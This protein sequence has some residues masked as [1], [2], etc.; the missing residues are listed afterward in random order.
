[1]DMRNNKMMRNKTLLLLTATL[2]V[3]F[4][5]VGLVLGAVNM[6]TPADNTNSS[7]S[8]VLNFTY[9][10]TTDITSPI[11]ANTT[12]YQLIS[13]TS[14]AISTS[15]SLTCSSTACWKTA[16]ASE[17]TDALSHT[18]WVSVGN[19]SSTG[20]INSTGNSTSLILYSSTPSCSFTLTDDDTNYLDPREISPTDGSSVDSLFTTTYAWTLFDSSN[21]VQTTD[22]TSTPS[23][24]GSDFDQIGE[25]TLA[26]TITD[27]VYNTA[28]CTND[29]IFVRG[30]GDDSSSSTVATTTNSQLENQENSRNKTLIIIAIA[31]AFVMFLS[32]IAVVIIQMTK[33][34]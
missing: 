34:K 13:G 29:T 21:N 26:L 23:F 32:A 31:I 20:Y 5:Y 3:T 19:A 18:I 16:T 14:T 8:V 25:F 27:D 17:L 30:N 28:T 24:S 1:M 6:V 22:T 9:T 2:L 12:F 7:G 11:D 4:M 33:K 15:A 10:N